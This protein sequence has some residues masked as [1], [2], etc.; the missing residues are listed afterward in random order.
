M[1]LKKP[2]G[3][4]VKH[5]KEP[6]NSQAAFNSSPQNSHDDPGTYKH[7]DTHE[8]ADSLGDSDCVSVFSAVAV[9]WAERLVDGDGETPPPA[10]VVA[11]GQRWDGHER[12]GVRDPGAW[13]VRQG[14]RR[15]DGLV[16]TVTAAEWRT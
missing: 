6:K 12:D 2:F 1:K 5:L 11:L 14:D 9:G 3:I 4:E 8:Q 10:S 16:V 13:R 15:D 7:T